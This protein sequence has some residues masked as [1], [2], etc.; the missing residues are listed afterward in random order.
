[1]RVV[2]QR[3]SSASVSVAGELSGAIGQGYLLLCGWEKGDNQAQCDRLAERIPRLRLWPGEQGKLA[4]D[5]LQTGGSVLVVPQFTL[6]A[7]TTDGLRPSF[8]RAAEPALARNLFDYFCDS[9]ART[10]TVQR[11]VFG[12]DMRV[13]LCNVG[14]FTLTLE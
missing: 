13:E 2:L 9:L 10:V 4:Y 1:M 3:V 14:P 12:A 7:N 8:T 5:L 6:L 11:G